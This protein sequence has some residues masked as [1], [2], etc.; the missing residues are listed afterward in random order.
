MTVFVMIVIVMILSVIECLHL[1]LIVFF[2][3]LTLAQLV[4]F[5]SLLPVSVVALVTLVGPALQTLWVDL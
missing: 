4:L 5:R 1:L 3:A 2:L